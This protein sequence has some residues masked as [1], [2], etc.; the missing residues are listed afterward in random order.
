VGCNRYAD[1]K[2]VWTIML[3]TRPL[4]IATQLDSHRYEQLTDMPL[5]VFRRVNE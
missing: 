3:C 2:T 5:C 1:S 4:R